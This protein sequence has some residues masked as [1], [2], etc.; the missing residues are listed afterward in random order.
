MIPNGVVA[1]FALVLSP[2]TRST[3]T[4]IRITGTVAASPSGSA[5]P[6]TGS[7]RVV[8][9]LQHST[10]LTGLTCSPTTFAGPGNVSCT[11]TLSAAV[12]RGGFS[13][14][15]SSSNS[16]VVVPASAFIPA[17]SSTGSFTGTVSSVTAGGT[18]MITASAR[19]IIRSAGIALSPAEVS[20]LSCSPSGVPSGNS[21]SCTVT[22]VS[23]APEGGATVSLS[24]SN[25]AVTIPPSVVVSLRRYDSHLHGRGCG[26]DRSRRMVN[27]HF[28]RVVR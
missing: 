22:L 28:E 27:R 16:Q 9:I 7:A 15:L 26:Y 23:A 11:V 20:F 19:G 12:P 8:N 10:N 2:S 5:I 13:V 4:A 24:S 14:D 6:T 25:A 18:A 1:Q 17:G 21:T 3:S